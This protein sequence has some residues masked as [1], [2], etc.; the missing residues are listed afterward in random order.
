MGRGYALFL[1][2]NICRPIIEHFRSRLEGATEV[3]ELNPRGIGLVRFSGTKLCRF[4]LAI[5]WSDC[6]WRSASPEGRC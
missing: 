1:E 6:L 3:I 2:T 4:R 5:R